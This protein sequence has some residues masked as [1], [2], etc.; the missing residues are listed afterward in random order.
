MTAHT[1]PIVRLAEP[2]DLRPVQLA[3]LAVAVFAAGTGLVLP[4]ISCLAA[5]GPSG[6]VVG[7]SRRIH[8][9]KNWRFTLFARKCVIWSAT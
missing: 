4:V 2:A 5:V 7:F 3:W 9:L 6:L 1:S 8:P